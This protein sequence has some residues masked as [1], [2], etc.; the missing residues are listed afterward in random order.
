[1]IELAPCTSC[2]GQQA[3]GASHAL[4]VD[5]RFRRFMFIHVD[6]ASTYL[7][8]QRTLIVGSS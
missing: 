4:G 8:K 6:G 1:M 2:T 7:V 3:I 5:E